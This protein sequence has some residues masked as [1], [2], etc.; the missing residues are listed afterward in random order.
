MQIIEVKSSSEAK[1]F[2]KFPVR[3]Y[4]GENNWVRPLDKNIDHVFDPKKNEYFQHG[5]C[6]RWL[7]RDDDGKVIGKVAAFIDEKSVNN[8]EQPTGGLGFFDCTN[9]QQA[10]NLLFDNCKSWLKARGMEAM[11]GP[12][13]FGDRSSWWGCLAMGYDLEPNYCMPYNF[14]YYV[15]LFKNYGF[16]VYFN[17]LT[18]ARRL[19]DGGGLPRVEKHAKKLLARYPGY[20]IQTIDMKNLPK[21]AEDFRIIYNKAWTSITKVK[22]REEHAKSIMKRMKPIIDPRLVLFAYYNGEPVG[23]CVMLPELNQI[24]KYVN[25]KLNLIGKLKLLYHKLNKTCDKAFGVIFGV[26]PDHQR[27]GVETIMIKHLNDTMSAL[28]SQYKAAEMNWIGD[29]NP[30]MMNIAKIA[31]GEVS[32]I[33]HTYRYLFDRKKE[34][35]R[36]PIIV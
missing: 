22:M 5:E 26:I 31:G 11:D 4:K 29:F 36:H 33:H 2:I 13:N 32:K 27:K 16:D 28:T 23:F 1:E 12:V 20:R 8:N 24:F 34:F 18:Y 19:D 25:G 21:F 30:R 10:A 3:L 7:L 14:P 15:D 17:Q 35:K 9:D 6:A